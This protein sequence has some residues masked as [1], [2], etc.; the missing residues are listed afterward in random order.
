MAYSLL[1]ALLSDSWKLEEPAGSSGQL[2]PTQPSSQTMA[3][4]LGG[5]GQGAVVT[6][7]SVMWWV[8]S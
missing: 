5:N 6:V 1:G 3:A 8:W 4:G 2:T 7:Q